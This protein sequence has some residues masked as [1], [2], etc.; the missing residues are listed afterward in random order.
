MK[1][2]T[3]TKT[4]AL[5]E[6]VP[7][8]KPESVGKDFSHEGFTY[9]KGRFIKDANILPEQMEEANKHSHNNRQRYYEQATSVSTESEDKAGE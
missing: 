8:R 7:E 9:K 6:V 2:E 3:K 1:N 4:Y 5:H